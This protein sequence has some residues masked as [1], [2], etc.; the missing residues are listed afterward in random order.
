MTVIFMAETGQG[1]SATN[2]KGMRRYT[3]AFLLETTDRT[4]GPF[5]VGSDLNLPVIGS[6]H[7]ED[8]NAWCVSLKVENSNPWKGWTV[9]ADYTSEREIT[10]DPTVE[11][12]AITW[13]SEQFQRP[14]I[15][16]NS[17]NAV[18]NS[19]G[20]PFDPP[21]MMDDSRPVVTISKNLAVV[22][23][24]ILAYQDA[25]NSDVF[26]VDGITVGIGLAK[27]QSVTV[28]EVQRRNGIMFRTVNLVIH[29]QRAGWLVEAQDVGFRELGTGGRQ[30]I[31]NDVDDE[32]PSAPVPL[33]GAGTHVVE[34]TAATN[35]TL[36]FGVY[37]TQVFSA[38]PL[39]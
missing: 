22:P 13:S 29:L 35:V 6:L 10:E 12:A 7:P 27:V 2:E 39:S 32:R 33:D 34:P 28:G 38:L 23:A 36:S 20:D 11:P 24:W 15:Y 31:V 3:R 30:N 25:V 18:V 26:Y 16:D 9:T 17:G 8:M 4:D 1:R 21:I 14:V 37:S 5:A 19:A